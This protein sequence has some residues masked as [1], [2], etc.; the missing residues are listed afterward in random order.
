MKKSRRV[1]YG[2]STIISSFAAFGFGDN[3]TM[4]EA[5][6]GNI[7]M[8]EIYGAGSITVYR[9]SEHTQK[10][11]KAEEFVPDETYYYKVVCPEGY[12]LNSMSG[13]SRKIDVIDNEKVCFIEEFLIY[14]EFVRAGDF[15]NDHTLDLK[16]AAE[17]IRYCAGFEKDGATFI[18][19]HELYGDFN[20][21]GELDLKDVSQIL[22]VLADL[23]KNPHGGLQTDFEIE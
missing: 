11:T 1:S 17:L 5:Y 6:A 22:R 18:Y 23:E 15:N 8:W 13:D 16:D 14:P 12:Y 2:N 19:D 10:I 3:D 4:Y 7:Y 21:D 9:D 20:R